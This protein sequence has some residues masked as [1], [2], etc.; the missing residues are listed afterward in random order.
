M[1][2]IKD[3]IAILDE[4]STCAF[5]GSKEVYPV[6]TPYPYT[7]TSKPFVEANSK[8]GIMFVCDDCGAVG[9]LSAEELEN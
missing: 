9:S 8:R 6:I 1:K 3:W 7:Y 5:C 2:T 4:N